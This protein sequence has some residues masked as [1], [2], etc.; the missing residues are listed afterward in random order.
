MNTQRF[1]ADPQ[2]LQYVIAWNEEIARFLLAS[3]HE[4]VAGEG[5]PHILNA[6]QLNKVRSACL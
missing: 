3:G 1:D 6:E 5:F 2:R 4:L